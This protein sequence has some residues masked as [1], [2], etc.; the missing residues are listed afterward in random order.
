MKRELKF[1]GLSYSQSQIGSYVAVLDEVRGTRKMVIIIRPGEAQVIAAKVENVKPRRPMTHEVIKAMTDSFDMD[2]QEVVI[3]NQA[4][5]TF[6]TKLVCTDGI[7]DHNIECSVG[8]GIAFSLVYDCPLYIEEAVLSEIGI[9][10]DDSGNIVGSEDI[11]K[12]LREIGIDPEDPR[13]GV[14][15]ERLSNNIQVLEKKMQEELANEN[16]EEAAKL[17]DKI[18]ELKEDGSSTE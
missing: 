9:E 4:E 5:G 13:F 10:I 3:Y 7:D 17:R 6:Y 15:K 16:Y 1:F 18:K 2:V 11:D 14:N 8:D 12:E